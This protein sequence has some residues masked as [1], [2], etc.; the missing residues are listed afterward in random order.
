MKRIFVII[1]IIMM[2]TIFSG[3]VVVAEGKTEASSESE[4]VE[5]VE[6]TDTAEEVDEKKEPKHAMSFR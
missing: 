2:I 4:P 6:T 5:T 3:A 1:S